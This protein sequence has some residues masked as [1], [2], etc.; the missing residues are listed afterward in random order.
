MR[1]VGVSGLGLALGLSPE[2]AEAKPNLGEIYEWNF[3]EKVY[4][5]QRPAIVLFHGSD[6]FSE[7]METVLENLQGIYGGS[8]DFYKLV[9]DTWRQDIRGTGSRREAL[10]Q[11]LF[12][13]E[14]PFPKTVMYSRH[15]VLTGK[16]YDKNVKIDVLR[17]GPVEDKWIK[18]WIVNTTSW[19]DFNILDV[20]PENPYVPRFLNGY[21]LQGIKKE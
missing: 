14:N 3:E 6:L 17:G 18:N 21:E 13:V 12:G 8:V 16:T 20:K 7:R 4:R 5:N 19:I 10:F 15:D 11:Q 1:L 2:E 9:V